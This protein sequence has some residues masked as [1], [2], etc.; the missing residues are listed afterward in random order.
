MEY[1]RVLSL[2]V[3]APVA[4]TYYKN[5]GLPGFALTVGLPTLWLRL[6]LWLWHHYGLPALQVAVHAHPRGS[7]G[8]LLTMVAGG[9]WAATGATPFKAM[10]GPVQT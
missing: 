7:R 2:G 4:N 10:G 3:D 8:H 6:R 1:V 9:G 5:S